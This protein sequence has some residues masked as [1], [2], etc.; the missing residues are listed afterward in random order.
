VKDLIGL[1]RHYITGIQMELKRKDIE[2]P[3]RNCELAAYFTHCNLQS[4]HT[5]LSLRSAMSVAYKIKNY[6]TASSFAKRLL[7][8]NP[9]PALATQARKVIA[10]AEKTPEDESKLN[11]DE[12]NPFVMCC[13]SYTPI[14]KGNALTK[15][16]F[17]GACYLPEHKRTVS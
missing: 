15:C 6:K 8:L 5:M 10:F 11:Y 9:A 1:C 2:D 13:A 17:C 7:E 16:P 4:S 3:V 12:R 14:Y